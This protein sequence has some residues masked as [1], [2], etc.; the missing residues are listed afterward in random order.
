[1]GEIFFDPNIQLFPDTHDNFI[2]NTTCAAKIILLKYFLSDI[3]FHEKI[4]ITPENIL[5]VLA[6]QQQYFELETV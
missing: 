1:M 5:M 6:S 4:N 3:L 2:E